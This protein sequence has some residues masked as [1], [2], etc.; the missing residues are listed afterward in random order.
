MQPFLKNLAQEIWK[1]HQPDPGGVCVVLPNRRGALFLKEYLSELAGKTIFSPEIYS[2]EDFISKLSGLQIIDQTEMLFALYTVY[3][4]TLQETADSFDVFSKWAPALLADFNE[5]DRYLVDARQLFVNLSSI[6]EIEN[7]SLNGP[8]LTEFQQKHILFWESIGIFYHRLRSRM[9]QEGKAWQGLAYRYVADNL[10][11]LI[12]NQSWP[13]IYFAGFNALNG[14]EEK[15]FTSLYRSGKAA[16]FWDTDTYYLNDTEQEAGKFLRAFRSR[17]YENE[18]LFQW[19]GTNLLTGSKKIV[20]T[21]AARNISQAKIAGAVL[22][23]MY[24][25]DTAL[26]STALVLAD[27]TLLFPVLHS[28]PGEIKGI[29]VT[30]GYPLKS[31]PMAS[32]FRLCFRLHMNAS[33]FSKG[34]RGSKRFYHYDLCALLRHPYVQEVFA[35]SNLSETL[36]RYLIRNNIIFAGYAQ[37]EKFCQGESREEWAKLKPLLGNW[38]SIPDCFLALQHL[39]DLLRTAFSAGKPEKKHPVEKEWLFQ[40]NGFM[41]RLES[42]CAVYPHVTEL[43][44]LQALFM[45]MADTSSIPF[46]G[47]PL[48]GLQVMGMLETRTL[49]FERI[50]LLSANEHILPGSKIQN[51]FIPHDLKKLFG[52]PLYTDKDAVF[53][54]HFFR[55]LQQAKEI[56]LI[57]NTESDTFGEGEKSRY[58]TQVLNELIRANPNIVVEENLLELP[59]LHE[60]TEPVVIQKATEVIERINK[61][62]EKGFSPTLL[63]TYRKCTLRFYLHY[64]A[65]IKEAQEVEEEV[66]ADTLGTVIHDVLEKLYTPFIGKEFKKEDPGLLKKGLEKEV[67]AAFSRHFPEEAIHNGKN[68]LAFRIA[69]RFLESFLNAETD[70][71]NA[72]H[73][74]FISELEKEMKASL[75]VGERNV[76]LSGKADR[77][78]R[79]GTRVRIIDYKTGKAEKSELQVNEWNDLLTDPGLDKSFQLLCYAWLYARS[80][81]MPSELISAIISLRQI[82]AGIKPVQTPAGNARL[83]KTELDEFEQIILNL[84]LEMYDTE[85]PFVQTT[86]K[87]V[88]EYCEFRSFCSR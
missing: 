56:H 83:G 13:K 21:G 86:E 60:E 42:L 61:L 15:I 52:L 6:R 16:L 80:E 40:F 27:E 37:L 28:I 18:K 23:D 55:L 31:T 17:H 73:K 77:I 9:E 72:G 35:Q 50:V 59:Y 14:A 49:D 4:E 5:T 87:E 71:L 64:V 76:F 81:G 57:Y 38:E 58:L 36:C 41:K 48:T 69:L 54:Y 85:K 51:S 11:E 8:D 43:N 10:D 34:R 67:L 3:S 29:N 24:R 63:N 88:C 22:R 62:A 82:K 75:R 2:T 74:L 26:H 84:V 39:I 66:G 79:E 78:D 32:L 70:F 45:Q 12:N 20:M 65:G 47:E 25:V 46:Y 44:T 19:T 30:M 68:F 53:A 7:W 1:N 33:K